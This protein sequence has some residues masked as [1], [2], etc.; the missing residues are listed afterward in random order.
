MLESWSK[1]VSYDSYFSQ[2]A[3]QYCTYSVTERRNIIF[4][5]TLSLGL[6]GGLNLALRLLTPWIIRI[7][8]RMISRQQRKYSTLIAQ[9]HLTVK[10]FS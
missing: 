7:I 6:F 1:N 3:P 5:I 2:C 8:F 10:H 4:L 9:Q